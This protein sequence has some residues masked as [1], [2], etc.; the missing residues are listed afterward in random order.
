MPRKKKEEVATKTKMSYADVFDYL[1]TIHDDQ[2]Y[3]SKAAT[4]L[5]DNKIIRD[6]I[7]YK[8]LRDVADEIVHKSCYKDDQFVK[9][10][11]TLDVLTRSSEMILYFN[12]EWPDDV[13]H[14]AFYD[15]Y[16]IFNI[17]LLLS[18]YIDY[19]CRLSNMCE[20]IIDDIEFNELSVTAQVRKILSDVDTD[21]ANQVN[22][23]EFIRLL[24]NQIISQEQ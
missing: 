9:D 8:I 2:D 13:D 20:L 1:S 3:L 4:Y 18:P 7:P 17:E 24:T 22:N 12:V 11:L 6:Y 5:K 16:R 10:S 14:V 15:L 19:A 23:P 21:M